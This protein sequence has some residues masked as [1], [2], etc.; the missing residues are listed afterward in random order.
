M[1][2]RLPF[3]SLVMDI[4]CRVLLQLRSMPFLTSFIDPLL[5]RFGCAIVG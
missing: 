5:A 1:T 3:Q 2:I 4:I